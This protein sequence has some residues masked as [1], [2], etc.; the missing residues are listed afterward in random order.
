[1]VDVSLDVPVSIDPG[2]AYRATFNNGGPKSIILNVVGIG[3]ASSQIP[4][5]TGTISVVAEKISSPALDASTVDIV[6]PS[7][8]LSDSFIISETISLSTPPSEIDGCTGG[9]SIEVTITE[10]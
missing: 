7:F 1:M 6:G 4:V 9:S 3:S 8:S 5:G 10:G 2:G